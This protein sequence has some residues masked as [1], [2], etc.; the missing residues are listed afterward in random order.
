M[1]YSSAGI[2]KIRNL[3]IVTDPTESVRALNIDKLAHLYIPVFF[4]KGLEALFLLVLVVL[5]KPWDRI[6]LTYLYEILRFQFG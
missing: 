3:F 6:Q 2:Y 1:L 5:A 4:S